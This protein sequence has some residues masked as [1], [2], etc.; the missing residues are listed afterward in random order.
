MKFLNAI[1]TKVM[2]LPDAT[3]VEVLASPTTSGQS[4]TYGQI[5][6]AAT[7]L[8]NELARIPT[9]QEHPLRIGLVMGN[10]AEWVVADLAIMLSGM[11]EV[12]IPLAFSATQAAGLLANTDI[13]IVDAA[14]ASKLATWSTLGNA[15]LLSKVIQIHLPTL[16]AT[17]GS[18]ANYQDLTLTAKPDYICKIIHTSGTTGNPKGVKIRVNGLDEMVT[19]LQQKFI[20]GTYTRYLSIL[21]LSVLIEQVTAIYMTM[22]DGGTLVF[23]PPDV[24][25]LGTAGATPKVLLPYLHQ[26]APSAMSN[27]PPSVVEAIYSYCKTY[28]HLAKE[29]L[30][31]QLFG[32]TKPPFLTCGGASTSPTTLQ[33]LADIGITVYE[34][35][36]LSENS[37]VVAINIP[38]QIKFGTVGKPL[39]HVQVK[40]SEDSEL[41]VKSTSLFDGYTT[42]DPSSCYFD[43]EGWL[44][45]G[46]I[47]DIDVEGFI[48]IYGR[49][50]NIIVTANGQNV[51]LEWVESKYKTLDFVEEVVIFGDK[52]EKIHGFFVVD[53]NI[54]ISAAKAMIES[55]GKQHLS[56]IEQVREIFIT[57]SN[58][59]IYRNYFTVTGRPMRDKI[60]ALII[61]QEEK[62]CQAQAQ[63]LSTPVQSRLLNM[64]RGM[65]SYALEKVTQH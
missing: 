7:S 65:V 36:G 28:N 16:L 54:D 45:T 42:T 19:A 49:K 29:Q 31:E 21:P 18:V 61:N 44:K 23:L 27:M 55:F 35:Y 12:P 38:S 39:D 3:A 47:A 20:S 26:A 8:S 57:S 58:N 37:S 60:W 10:S 32:V 48:R 46:D 59:E 34:G 62:V 53:R 30:L 4:Y 25:P 64:V 50:K 15:D 22:I 41:L 14:G 24:P 33:G 63:S 1:I 13:C 6:S 43:S 51:S 11:T 17:A 9:T 5:L 40:L 2:Q 56:E 52:L